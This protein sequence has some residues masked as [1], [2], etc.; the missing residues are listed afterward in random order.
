M[1]QRWMKIEV[2]LPNKPEVF[3]MSELL[4]IDA[5][6]IVGK[7]N[8]VWGW[9]N[10]HSVDGVEPIGVA[11][12]LN[13]LTD[14]ERFCEAMA[15]V[16][17]LEINKKTI[18]IPNFGLHNGSGAKQRAMTARRQAKHRGKDALQLEYNESVTIDTLPDKNRLE[19][20]RKDKSSSPVGDALV[21]EDTNLD[22]FKDFKEKQL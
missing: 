14:N 12:L 8:R 16:G 5:D 20:I 22:L 17:W 4:G 11:G 19:E 18:K 7:L 9:F 13:K 21:V 3:E 6:C 1:S 15:E 2:T 10:E